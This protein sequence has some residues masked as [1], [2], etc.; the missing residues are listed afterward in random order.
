M[1]LWG[2]Y[3]QWSDPDFVKA[4]AAVSAMH[5]ESALREVQRETRQWNAYALKE[6][7]VRAPQMGKPVEVYPRSGVDALEVYSRPARDAQKVLDEGG[8]LEEAWKAFEERINGITAADLQIA[9]RDEQ[10]LIEQRLL[11]E[12]LLD[13]V[14]DPPD[15]LD[16]PSVTDDPDDDMMPREELEKLLEEDVD[17]KVRVHAGSGKKVIGFR[18]VIRPELSK[19]GSCGLCVV[20]ATNWYTIEHLKPIHH[21]CKCV[22]VPV[23]KDEDPGFRWNQEDLRRNLDAIYGAAGGTTS[24]D[25][26]KRIRVKITEH[27]EL[28]S[29][30]EY[31]KKS[32]WQENGDVVP[33]RPGR[34]QRPDIA[35]QRARLTGRREELEQTLDN[36]RARLDGGGDKS[37][38]EYAIWEVQQSLKDLGV[39]LA[40]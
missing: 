26:L 9:E 2:N 4:R 28:G 5:V 7:G 13:W 34:Y 14:D 30:L 40:A 37:G 6:I 27:G 17:P 21:L 24:G 16:R 33:H 3:S 31:R 36:L 10:L 25:K 35:A 23:T 39:R 18:R 1:G 8:S 19:H 22:T 11:E 38:I 15:D 29:M 12:D 20:A 32:G